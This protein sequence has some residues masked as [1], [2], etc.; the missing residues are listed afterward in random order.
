[1]RIDAA[2]LHYRELNDQIRRAVAAG[3]RS[4]D[5]LNVNGQRY[6]GDENG[7]TVE[8][9]CDLAC[10]ELKSQIRRQ[11]DKRRTLQKRAQLSLKKKFS[12][13]KNARF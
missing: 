5:L 12:I 11:T 2:T 9:A 6:I 10:D 13:D 1:M 8:A 4:F 3:E 7:Q